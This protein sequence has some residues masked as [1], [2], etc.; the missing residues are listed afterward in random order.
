M[1]EATIMMITIACLLYFTRKEE[2]MMPILAR[3]YM[4]IGISNISPTG[5]VNIV[6]ELTNAASVV[7][8]A[9]SGLTLYDERKVIAIGEIRK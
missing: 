3:K 4:M 1:T 5:N 2:E 6:I 9:I 7:V 8:L